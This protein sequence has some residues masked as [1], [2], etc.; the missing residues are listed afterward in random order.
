M[1]ETILAALAMVFACPAFADDGPWFYEFEF[2]HTLPGYT[3]RLIEPDCGF[4]VPTQYVQ[5][6]AADP[7]PGWAVACG[8]EQPMFFGALGR[9]CGKLGPVKFEC[10]WR[11]M[12]SPNDSHEITFDG[13][14]V[15]GRISWGGK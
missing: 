14:G 10:L 3:D 2:S 4:V 12:S 9:K 15:R 6:Y 8:N 5:W 13:F 7:R 11:H 1:K